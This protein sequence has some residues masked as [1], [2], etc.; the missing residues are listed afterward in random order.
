MVVVVVVADL[1]SACTSLMSCACCT[2]TE[3][4]PRPSTSEPVVL[5]GA[6]IFL[7]GAGVLGVE[8]LVVRGSLTAV[9]AEVVCGPAALERFDANGI[10]LV[11]F[12]NLSV[13]VLPPAKSPLPPLFALKIGRASGGWEVACLA[14]LPYT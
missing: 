1:E 11:V 2:A 12:V 6:S 9:W 8:S 10:S 13:E 7:T 4:E 5:I 14:A 3:P